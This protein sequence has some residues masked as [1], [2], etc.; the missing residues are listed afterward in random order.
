M[1]TR[2]TCNVCNTSI[3]L[4]GEFDTNFRFTTVHRATGVIE[5]HLICKDHDELEQV[6]YIEDIQQRHRALTMAAAE[7]ASKLARA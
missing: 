7:A 1:A 2:Q 3:K 6:M 5:H 4:R